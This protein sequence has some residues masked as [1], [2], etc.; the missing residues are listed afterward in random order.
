MHGKRIAELD[1]LRGAAI[2]G[3]LVIHSSFK[4]RFNQETLAVQAIMA[5]LF[6]WAVLAFFFSSGFLYDSS[7]PFTMA[8]RKRS[9]SL[10]VPFLL[11]N[12]FYNLFFVG[13]GDLGWVH[14]NAF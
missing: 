13:T 2:F 1:I 7:V 11:Y 3:V 14:N 4:G 12:A 5:R 6:D 9:V 8:V 10:L